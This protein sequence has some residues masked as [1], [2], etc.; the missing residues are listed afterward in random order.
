[1]WSATAIC[2]QYAWLYTSLP[3]PVGTWDH[4]IPV[5]G[6]YCAIKIVDGI[7]YVCWR[8]S[9][10][11]KDWLEDFQN[12]AIPVD[13]PTLGLV[14]P[15][16]ASVRAILPQIRQLI[17]KLPVVV[18][19]HS[20]GAI[21]AGQA[22]ALLIAE[23]VKVLWVLMFGEPRSSGPTLSKIYIDAK[24]PTTSY[25]N[26]TPGGGHD[27]VTDVPEK[28]V[29]GPVDFPYQHVRD[30]LADCRSD[31]P[32]LDEWGPFAWHHFCL[33]CRAFGCGGQAAIS[34]TA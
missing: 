16:V 32:A 21:H 10:T 23:D 9:T 18:V 11:E 7:A 28:I 27:D 6:A 19:G 26:A 2:D 34:L 13:D 15:A 24:V 20:L 12:F 3:V 29:I 17:G 1:M 8:G 30:P 5:D 4:I 25:R 22:G 14:H 31:P 33:Y